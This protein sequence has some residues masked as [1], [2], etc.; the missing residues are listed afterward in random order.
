MSVDFDFF[1]DQAFDPD[2]LAQVI[3]YLAE[4]ERVQ[5]DVNTLTCRVE[6]GGPVLISFFGHLRLG[7]VAARERAQ[8]LRLHVASLLDLAG[9]K[10][11]V[12]QKRA[13]EKDYLD[14][15]ALIRNGVELPLALVFCH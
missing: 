4:A 11:S 15:D 13:Q 9:T 12:V 5:V 10:V 14:V 7:Q 8:G 1:S 6:R 2:R 3:P